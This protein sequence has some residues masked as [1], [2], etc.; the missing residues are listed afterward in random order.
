[1]K[2]S[3]SVIRSE[4]YIVT[5]VWV[6]PSRVHIPAWAR[7]CILLETPIKYLGPTETTIWWLPG[8]FLWGKAAGARY[9]PLPSSAKFKNE[10]SHTLPPPICLNGL[11]RGSFVLLMFITNCTSFTISGRGYNFLSSLKRPEWLW[12]WRSLLCI[13]SSRLFSQIKEDGT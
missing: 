1:M 8:L 4:V 10:W 7:Y 9:W 6:G 13:G 2:W 12:G 3:S 11:D 5:G